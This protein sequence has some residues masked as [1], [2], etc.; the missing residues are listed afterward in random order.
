M[1]ATKDKDGVW[2]GEMVACK[3]CAYYHHGNGTCNR[4]APTP[5]EDFLK[6]IYD[7]VRVSIPKLELQ[8]IG[9]S[10]FRW[11]DEDNFCGEFLRGAGG[12]TM[13]LEKQKEVFEKEDKGA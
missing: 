9:K 10:D 4:H 12:G 8:I 1:E 2:R 7:E 6:T 5:L 11:V 13:T 3:W